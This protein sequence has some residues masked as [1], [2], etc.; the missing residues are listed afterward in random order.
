M[1]DSLK[2][3]FDPEVE[4]FITAFYNAYATYIRIYKAFP[5]QIEVSHDEAG[6]QIS[7]LEV[8]TDATL[9]KGTFWLGR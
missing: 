5:K 8:H 4:S 1:K 6:C 2:F 7:L 3:V 9:S